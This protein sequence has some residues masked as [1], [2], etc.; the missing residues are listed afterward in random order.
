MRNNYYCINY[1]TRYILDIF[2]MIFNMY[3]NMNQYNYLNFNILMIWKVAKISS[4]L[5][6]SYIIVNM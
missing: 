3:I 4:N 6:C 1:Q 2:F 5:F